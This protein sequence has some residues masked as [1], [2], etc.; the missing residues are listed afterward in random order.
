MTLTLTDAVEQVVKQNYF[1]HRR[2]LKKKLCVNKYLY[3]I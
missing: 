2:I 1:L 3:T